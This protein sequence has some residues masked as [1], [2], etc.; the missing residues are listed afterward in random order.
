MVTEGGLGGGRQGHAPELWFAVDDARAAADR[1]RELGGTAGDP[2][3]GEHGTHVR[4]TD[5][6]GVAFGIGQP[7]R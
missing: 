2:S 4:C 6:Q 7:A 3:V 1:V 5:D